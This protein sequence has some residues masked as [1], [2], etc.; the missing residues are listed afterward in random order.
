[1]MLFKKY[2]LNLWLSI[3]KVFLNKMRTEARW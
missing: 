3:G 2:G 1:M